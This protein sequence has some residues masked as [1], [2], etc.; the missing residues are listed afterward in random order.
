MKNPWRQLE[1]P[2][3]QAA[4]EWLKEHSGLYRMMHSPWELFGCAVVAGM[5]A[6]AVLMWV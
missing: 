4:H 3:E 5:L 2:A 6:I 1:N